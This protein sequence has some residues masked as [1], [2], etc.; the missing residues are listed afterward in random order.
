MGVLLLVIAVALVALVAVM[1]WLGL[2]GKFRQGNPSLS[3]RTCHTPTPL[4]QLAAENVTLGAD[5]GNSVSVSTNWAI[6]GAPLNGGKGKAYLYKRVLGTWDDRQEIQASDGSDNDSFGQSVSINENIVVVGAPWRD[7]G[8]V[9]VFTLQG[10]TW[11]E[12]IRL[13]ASDGETYDMFGVKVAI[14]G[15]TLLVGAQHKDGGSGAAYVFVLAGDGSWDEGTRLIPRNVTVSGDEFGRSVALSGDRA[16]IGARWRDEKGDKSVAY[17]FH[18]MNGVWQEEA[19]LVPT[20]GAGYGASQEYSAG[21]DVAISGDTAFIGSPFDDDT[22]CPTGPYDY[23]DYGSR[24]G[25]VYV[26]IRQDNVTWEEVQNLTPADRKKDDYFGWR[27][28]ISGDTAVIGA[29]RSGYGMDGSG[30]VYTTQ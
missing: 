28:A 1:T 26:F 3:P 22:N 27:V 10:E 23:D 19:K 12:D 8:A 16:L 21:Y 20:G 6:V 7:S 30:Y 5:F 18:R 24:S 13:T 15:D 17:I 29:K 4:L 14:S 11:T 9:Y 25:S 2:T